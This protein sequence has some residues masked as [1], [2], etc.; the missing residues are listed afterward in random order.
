VVSKLAR[1]ENKVRTI[2]NKVANVMVFR[3]GIRLFFVSYLFLVVN[4]LN[5]MMNT[6]LE[7]REAASYAIGCITFTSLCFM[8]FLVYIRWA[9]STDSEAK[10]KF[11]YTAELV[12]MT[13][14]TKS[15]QTYSF[16]WPLRRLLVAIFV[17]TL[18]STSYFISL[19]FVLVVQVAY[20]AYL[21][22]IRP[23]T[24][25]RAMIFEIVGEII[26]LIAIS[27]VF[28]LNDKDQWTPQMNWVYI[29]IVYAVG[30]IHSVISICK[31]Y[32]GNQSKAN[33]RH[34]RYHGSECPLQ[35]PGE[36]YVQG[37]EQEQD[38]RCARLSSNSIQPE[39]Q[40]R[41]NQQGKGW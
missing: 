13:R 19:S 34:D 26:L 5:E 20:I 38:Q 17:L 28:V 29:S 37:Q 15:A 24:S 27:M 6:Y 7:H 3:V 11:K 35:H 2:L 23:L 8:T 12:N 32:C 18:R 22:V 16:V 1:P 4:S 40:Q 25:L 39:Y 30:A 36:A 14:D 31:Y 9:F 10:V 41:I 33:F 21:C